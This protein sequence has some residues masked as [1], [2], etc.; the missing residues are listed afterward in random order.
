M[1]SKEDL[2]HYHAQVVDEFQAAVET[3]P[4]NCAELIATKFRRYTTRKRI[5]RVDSCDSKNVQ[6]WNRAPATRAM[7][8]LVSAST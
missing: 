5:T 1:A 8:V 3:S 2:N 7:R 4:N 6:D